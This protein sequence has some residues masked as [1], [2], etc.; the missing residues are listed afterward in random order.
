MGPVQQVPDVHTAI[1]LGDV[2]DCRA[3]WRPVACCEALTG[4]R[5]SEDGTA[6]QGHRNSCEK[7]AVHISMKNCSV[8]SYRVGIIL[9]MYIY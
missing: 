6:L 8:Y 9:K 4:C 5:R 1:L 7:T 2:E 3:T